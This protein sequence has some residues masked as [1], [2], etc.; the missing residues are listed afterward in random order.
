MILSINITLVPLSVDFDSPGDYFLFIFHVL[1][2]TSTVIVAGSVACGIIK[3]NALLRQNRFIFMLNTSISDTLT[4]CGIFYQCLFDVRVGFPSK[5]GTYY[6]LT[7]L[8]GV[9]IMT[10]LFAQFDRYFAVC[11]PFFYGR[12]ITTRV[13]VCLNVYSWVHVYSQLLIQHLV[14][15]SIAVEI[16]VYSRISLMLIIITKIA[17]TIKLLIVAK[18][19]LQ[20]EPP[21]P[22]RDSKKESLLII[23]VVVMS[24][25]LLWSPGLFNTILSSLTG[26]YITKNEA[27]NPLGFLTRSNALCTPSLYLS[28]SPS[29][30]TAVWKSVWSKICC[31]KQPRRFVS[32]RTLVGK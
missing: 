27:V 9:N 2:G 17:M 30:R 19:Q 22:E 25:L 26:K 24:F 11:H 28:A 18:Q 21:G 20:R 14:P 5:N 3:T 12:F 15:L 7:S 16:A 10:F 31:C 8:L 23:V 1:V 32:A 4:G 13:T 29:L 6:I